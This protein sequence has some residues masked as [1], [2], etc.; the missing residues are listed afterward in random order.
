MMRFKSVFLALF[1]VFFMLIMAA[2]IE[3]SNSH[4]ECTE[5]KWV[6][7]EEATCTDSGKQ[8]KRCIVCDKLIETER[9]RYLGHDF[10]ETVIKETTCYEDGEILIECTRCDYT[11]EM[12]ESSSGHSAGEWVVISEPNLG[13]PGIKEKSCMKC[14]EVLSTADFVN[15]GFRRYG[16]LTVNQNQLLDYNNRPVQLFGLSTHGFNFFPRFINYETFANAQAE[17]G[18]NIIRLAMYT[19]ESGGYCQNNGAN[20]EKLLKMMKD[21]VQYATDLD[22]YA[23]VD[24]HQVGAEEVADKNPLSY[25]TYAKEFFDEISKTYKDNDN[26]L[27][28]ICNEPNGT[29]TWADIKSYAN[30]VIPVIRANDPDAIIIVGTPRWSADLYS[31]MNDPLKYDNLMYTFHFYADSHKDYHRTMVKEAYDAKLPIFVTEHALMGS[32]GYGQMNLTSGTAWYSL[33]DECKISYVAWNISTGPSD[34]SIFK[35]NATSPHDFSNEYLKP[36][37]VWIKNF[38]RNKAGL[39]ERT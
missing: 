34:S 10:E 32:D 12:T 19:S 15:N 6:V 17:F 27:Y 21:A 38:Y 23:I 22:L 24:W 13:K 26:I 35:S 11:D 2:C 7:I 25:V 1:L 36:W 29:T 37:G 14:G 20:Q 9:I 28:E 8:E 31:P 3:P 30:Q 33:L 39:S 16:K 5:F 4:D 18:I